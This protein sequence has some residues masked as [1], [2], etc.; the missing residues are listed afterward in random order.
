MMPA[1]NRPETPPNLLTAPNDV[2][3]LRQLFLL[4][5]I[6]SGAF[7]VA[8]AV[9]RWAQVRPASGPNFEVPETAP[10]SV[11][12]AAMGVRS[13][14]QLVAYVLVSSRCGFCQMQ[15]TKDA[16]AALRNLMR[17]RSPGDFQ[18]VTVVGVAVNS[19]L[20]EG[21]DYINSIGLGSFDQISVGSGWLNEQIVQLVWRDRAADPKVPQVVLVS[22]TMS[23]TLKPLT[24]TYDGDSVLRV[25]HGHKALVSWVK[26][27]ANLTD[28]APT[29]FARAIQSNRTT[30][31]SAG[32]IP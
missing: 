28:T 32:V 27:G 17:L 4:G 1:R 30:A 21:L 11:Q 12:L 18:S 5:V 10:D 9:K 31:V 2:R 15:D 25:V 23:A 3:N 22:R 29:P 16:I 24:L 13:G 19:D 7:G 14:R 20:R 8:V 26:G 6:G